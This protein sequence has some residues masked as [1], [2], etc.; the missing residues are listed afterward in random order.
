MSS[1][2]TTNRCLL[3]LGLLLSWGPVASDNDFLYNRSTCDVFGHIDGRLATREDAT[4]NASAH[5][6]MGFGCSLVYGVAKH[7]WLLSPKC[8][9]TWLR[10]NLHVAESSMA[11]GTEIKTALVSR[12]ET[13]TFAIVRNPTDRLISAYKTVV[14][15]GSNSPCWRKA[16]PW[17]RMTNEPARFL[18]YLRELRDVGPTGAKLGA[19]PP[20][21]VWHH[22]WS[23]SLFL[24]HAS[25]LAP[26]R[27]SK[28]IRLEHLQGD[29]SKVLG[30]ATARTI[31]MSAYKTLVNSHSE[32]SKRDKTDLMLVPGVTQFVAEYYKQ[33][34]IC[35]G[36]PQPDLG[37][38]H[39]TMWA[40]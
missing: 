5:I 1:R 19:C 15:R 31:K 9:S 7:M 6:E 2:V 13:P 34:Y 14:E 23:Q 18:A 32:E 27:T 8:G 35:L 28:I 4:L 38:A 37:G 26:L 21:C 33:D 40:I 12:G 25:G 22:P 24:F 39:P 17:L 11:R 36:Y 10:S 29:L 3:L 30:S 16:L 20:S